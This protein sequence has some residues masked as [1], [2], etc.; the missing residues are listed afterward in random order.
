[1]KKSN[2]LIILILVL[3][4]SAPI[5][6]GL[7]M[8]PFYAKES[9]PTATPAGQPAAQPV[10]QDPSLVILPA[11]FNIDMTFYSQAPYGNWKQPWQDAC[12]E[13]SLLLVAN[14][15]NK[16]DWTRSQFND[17]ILKLVDWEVKT[18]GSYKENPADQIIQTLKD[19][20][21]LS[22]VVHTDPTLEDVQKIL[23][24]G[25]LIIIP[26]AGKEIGNPNFQNGGP[27]YHAIVIKGYTKDQ[28]IITEDVGTS[29]GENYIYSWDTL[30]K[31][32]HDYIIPIDDGAKVIIEVVPN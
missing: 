4:I 7:V 5:A 6:Y 18:Y 30:Q 29:H 9:V 27:T 8:Q 19:Q 32:N 22:S 10:N 31:A 21:N 12:E 13:A 11:E 14:T 17:Q 2:F 26:L 15:Y 23:A 25:H 16:Y 20:F 24:Q 3:A 28:K 1:M